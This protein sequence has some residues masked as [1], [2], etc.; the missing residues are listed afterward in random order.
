MRL[1]I[2]LALTTVA[3]LVAPTITGS[4]AT[5]LGIWT[6]ATTFSNQVSLRPTLSAPDRA[7]DNPSVILGDVEKGLS[8]PLPEVPVDVICERLTDAAQ[9]SGLP[10]PFFARL[11]WQESKFNP[12][13]VSPV[14][15]PWKCTTP[16]STLTGRLAL[17]PMKE[18]TKG[19]FGRS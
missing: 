16:P 13:A 8:D 2:A 9:S 5:P 6:A 7:I 4:G 11:I 3:I 12:R 1:L 17:S 15:A 14:G 10:A 18:K 19:E